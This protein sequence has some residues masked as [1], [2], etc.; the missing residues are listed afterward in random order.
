MQN[1]KNML[2]YHRKV[3]IMEKKLTIKD[4]NFVTKLA[5]AL[6]VDMR[7]DILNIL[8]RGDCNISEL[9]E[10]LNA[11]VSTIANHL[12]VLEEAGIIQTRFEP[13]IRGSQKLASITMSRLEIVTKMDTRINEVVKTTFIDMPVGNY[14]DCDVKGPC[15]MASQHNHIGIIDDP[16][17]FYLSNR[18]DAKL[19]W[20]TSGSLTYKFYNPLKDIEIKSIEFI[21][22]C[23]SEAPGHRNDFLSDITVWLNDLEITTFETYGDYAD[24]RGDLTPSWWHDTLT[25]YGQMVNIKISDQGCFVN[26]RHVS[27]YTINDIYS[28]VMTFKIGVKADA[29]HVGGLNLFGDAFGDYKQNIV[30]KVNYV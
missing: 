29:E 20:F 3:M 11:P 1:P 10:R 22:E 28:E 17:S 18:V 5:K 30:L 4:K 24:R 8:N 19:I 13:G 26:Q 23:C 12:K 15:G 21:F 2:I 7:V 14:F 6:S 16:M 27:N 9:S 25:Q